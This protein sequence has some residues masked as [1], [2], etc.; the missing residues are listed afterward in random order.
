MYIETGD[1]GYCTYMYVVL[2]SRLSHSLEHAREVVVSA[3]DSFLPLGQLQESGS[4]SSHLL[5][6]GLKM[7]QDEVG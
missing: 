5:V 3:S 4:D 7:W 1:L 6:Y 2:I